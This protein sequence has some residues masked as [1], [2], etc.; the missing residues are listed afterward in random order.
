MAYVAGGAI[1]L[2]TGLLA[3][4]M[5]TQSAGAN[6]AVAKVPN[7]LEATDLFPIGLALIALVRQ[8]SDLGAR[9]PEERR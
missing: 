8:A 1:G 7:K 5:Y 6:N 9:K 4:R 3:A 2:V